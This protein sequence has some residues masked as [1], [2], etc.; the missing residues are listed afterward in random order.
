MRRGALHLAVRF[1]PALSLGEIPADRT[2]RGIGSGNRTGKAA[3]H[4]LVELWPQLQ[5]GQGA[6]QAHIQTFIPGV[7]EALEHAETAVGI[8][9]RRRTPQAAAAA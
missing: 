9:W 4:G 8:L 1:H 3:Q 6:I 5:Q 2:L 7:V